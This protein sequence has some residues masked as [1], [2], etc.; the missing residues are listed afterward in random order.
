M[1]KNMKKSSRLISLLLV[2]MMV[3]T[4]MPGMAWATAEG[5]GNEGEDPE[6]VTLT[7]A[8]YNGETPASVTLLENVTEAKVDD[9]DCTA[10]SWYVVE[11]NGSFEGA[12]QDVVDL[13]FSNDGFTMVDV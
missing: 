9:I 1:K 2:F 5:G 11:V 3:F 12:Q 13:Q 8:T 4:M 10:E 7:G 6:G